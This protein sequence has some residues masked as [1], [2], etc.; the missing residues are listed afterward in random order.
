MPLLHFDYTVHFYYNS[1]GWSASSDSK[2]PPTST[3]LS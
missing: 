1:E 3:E 2:T